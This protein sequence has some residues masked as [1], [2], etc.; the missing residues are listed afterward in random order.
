MILNLFE[1]LQI[2]KYR[3]IIPANFEDKQFHVTL[4]DF[5]E[6]IY[7]CPFI[8]LPEISKTRED[9]KLTI[10]PMSYSQML[11]VLVRYHD[12]GTF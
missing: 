2:N 1:Y 11:I 5:I 4:H 12:T 7:P 9:C 10:F 6:L 3:L 8:N